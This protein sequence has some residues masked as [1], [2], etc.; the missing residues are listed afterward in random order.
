M[1]TTFVK[2]ATVTVGAGGASNM[3]F[4]SI[5]GTY[6][7]LYLTI[8]SR[9]SNANVWSDIY[10]QFNGSTSTYSDRV[11]FGTGAAASSLTDTNTGIDIRTSTT[12]NTAST[13][14]NAS[15]YI[16]NYAS[17]NQKSVSFD[18]VSENNATSAIAQLGA[19]LWAST[20]AIT[21]LSVYGAGGNFVQYST[22]TLYG[23]SKS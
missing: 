21:S 15:V 10:V 22:A 18:A 4:T 14:G 5:P 17:S 6:T 1:A 9:I 19:G 16:P 11:V 23:I 13:F 8:S 7:D 12:A 20:P 3:D 2:I